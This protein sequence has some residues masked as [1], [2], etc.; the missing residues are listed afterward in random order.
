MMEWILMAALGVLAMAAIENFIPTVWSNELL[1]KLRET[2]VF[3]N[4]VNRKYEGEIRQKGD[5]VKINMIGPVTI[6]DYTRYGD[7]TFQQLTDASLMLEI[8]EEK[9]WA[10]EVDDVD[11]AQ[12]NADLR[13]DAM[14][15]AAH[16]LA[17]VADTFVAAKHSDAGITVD[18]SGSAFDVN[19]DNALELIMTLGQEM[20]EGNV[21]REGRWLVVPPWYITKLAIAKVIDLR[22]QSTWVNGFAG[23]VYGFGLYMSNNIA[24]TTGADYRIMAG[25]PRTI[26]YADQVIKTEATRRE[27][28]F[29]D[30]LKGLHVYGAKVIL[31]DSLAVLRATW[32]AE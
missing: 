30:G 29:R 11:A 8:T 18:D 13:T 23:N 12:A 2:F 15:E 5:S 10:F 22:D 25:I 27:L 28:G 9:Y 24:N 16:G 26:S 1:Q 21:P 17:G 31:P 14:A 3:G 4:V 32:A 20:D 19:S 6:N 7:I